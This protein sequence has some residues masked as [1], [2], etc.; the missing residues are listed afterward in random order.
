MSKKEDLKVFYMKYH[1]GQIRKI[2]AK[3]EEEAKK[4]ASEI[5]PDGYLIKEFYRDSH[6]KISKKE[7]KKYMEGINFDMSTALLLS[8]I[9]KRRKK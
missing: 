4:L 2:I 1:H 8:H 3:D 9:A 7:M 6:E 5:D